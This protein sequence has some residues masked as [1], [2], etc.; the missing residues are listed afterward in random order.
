MPKK[1]M[2]GGVAGRA[3]TVRPQE[4]TGPQKR[5]D[6]SDEASPGAAEDR[7]ASTDRKD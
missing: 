1:E 4:K 2:P 6:E 7:E 5:H 3:A